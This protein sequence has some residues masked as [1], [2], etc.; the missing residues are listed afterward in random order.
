MGLLV[1]TLLGIPLGE[2]VVGVDEDAAAAD[3]SH[4]T[5]ISSPLPKGGNCR[6]GA[7]EGLPTCL[8]LVVATMKEL[9]LCPQT[10]GDQRGRLPPRVRAG[11]VR[12]GGLLWAQG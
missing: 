1:A 12:R 3:P 11:E 4:A 10:A 9:P 8:G 2:D 7:G 6:P 5:R